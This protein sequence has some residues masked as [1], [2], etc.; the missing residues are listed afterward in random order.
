MLWDLPQ[1]SQVGRQSQ[2]QN[3]LLQIRDN[4]QPSS[5]HRRVRLPQGVQSRVGAPMPRPY[6]AIPQPL[7]NRKPS[8]FALHSPECQP[9]RLP[10]PDT[11]HSPP[12]ALPP[13]PVLIFPRMANLAATFPAAPS[14]RRPFCP[15]APASPEPHRQHEGA[16]G[17]ESGARR[18]AHCFGLWQLRDSP[19]I[20]AFP[21]SVNS[22]EGVCGDVR[23]P[24]KLIDQ[25]NDTSDGR[26]MWLAPILPGLVGSRGDFVSLVSVTR[27]SSRPSESPTNQN[28]RGPS[29]RHRSSLTPP[30]GTFW[31]AWFFP[32]AL[33]V[34]IARGPGERRSHTGLRSPRA[35][36]ICRSPRA[37]RSPGHIPCASSPSRSPG[38]GPQLGLPSGPRSTCQLSTDSVSQISDPPAGPPCHL[39]TWGGPSPPRPGRCWSRERGDRPGGDRWF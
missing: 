6:P 17:R 23:T 22:L 19:D 29:G 35:A 7:R 11:G 38:T 34:V 26:H 16:G 25:V 30:M 36:G 31:G 3:W 39:G 10:V 9:G 4:V 5:S 24:D 32:F 12:P 14:S 15:P 20:A 18:P 21:D 8:K 33:G 37:A 27:L 2:S 1:T 13:A 28:A